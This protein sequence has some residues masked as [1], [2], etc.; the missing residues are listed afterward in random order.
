MP[1]RSELPN[2]GA[3]SF[4]GASLLTVVI[5]A[6]EPTELVAGDSALWTRDFSSYPVTEGWTLAYRI[7]GPSA[8]VGNPTVAVANNVFNVTVLPA[9]TAA[10]AI[11]GDYTL[12]GY[13]TSQDGT[14]RF[15]VYEGT[16]LI[17][18]NPATATFTQIQTHAQ[19]MIAACEAALEGRLT[20]DVA[21]YGREGT[22]VV[23]LDVAEV[24]RT[25]GI[26]RGIRW[27]EE[28]EGKAAPI[29]VVRFSSPSEG[30]AAEKLSWPGAD[31]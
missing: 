11:L 30:S 17:L 4:S 23:K 3:S 1:P 15:T 20:N 2:P 19:R 31:Q 14:Q 5:P 6:A 7:I 27:Q 29:S 26:Y 24:R 25:L 28:N 13:V 12:M 18:P 8:T 16:L 22:M 21:S 10:L 9:V